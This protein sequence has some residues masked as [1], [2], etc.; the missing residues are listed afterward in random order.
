MKFRS[1]AIDSR[2]HAHFV[3]QWQNWGRPFPAM[4]LEPPQ[5]QRRVDVRNWF[6]ARGNAFFRTK[7]YEMLRSDA[8]CPFSS[9]V[10][11]R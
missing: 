10:R 8:K 2:T 3:L 5:F 4:V 9:F 6:A 11:F 1:T 7:T